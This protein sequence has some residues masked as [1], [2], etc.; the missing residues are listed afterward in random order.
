MMKQ[1]F[2]VIAIAALL[3]PSLIFAA[4][5]VGKPAPEFTLKDQSGKAHTLSNYKGKTVVLEWTNPECPFVV[6]HYK[7]KTMTTLA[8]VYAN[9]NV[10]WLAIDSSHFITP[11]QSKA[12][13]KKHKINYPTLQD[14][15]GEV[16]KLYAAKTTPHMFVIDKEG[17]LRYKGAIDNDS[18]GSK[19]TK[20]LK[21]YVDN[22]IQ[23]LQKGGSPSPN[24][25][26]PYGCSVKYK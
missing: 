4:P 5:E 12:W 21:N 18:W 17:I 20:K 11:D 13:A 7:T 19:S 26:K 10:V 22:S 3:L 8:N 16:G 6:R 2:G 15:K 24:S 14:P 25:T 23:A 1:L 9:K